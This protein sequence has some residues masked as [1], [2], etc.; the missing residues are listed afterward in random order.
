MRP[1][2]RHTATGVSVIITLKYR[3]WH[4][5]YPVV[6]RGREGGR[7]GGGREGEG[8]GEGGGGGRE[9]VREGGREGGREGRWEVSPRYRYLM[10]LKDIY[11]LALYVW[12]DN[13]CLYPSGRVCACRCVG[14][15]Q[16]CAWNEHANVGHIQK[17]YIQKNIQKKCLTSALYNDFIRRELFQQFLVCYGWTV[18]RCCVCGCVDGMRG[19]GMRGAGGFV[20]AQAKASNADRLRETIY[21][22]MHTYIHTHIYI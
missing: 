11:A 20:S 21:M 12:A 13:V 22:Y 4:P 19:A 3:F 6:I 8:E 18:A 10:S 15:K 2:A 9:A 7:E 14:G 16:L 5:W 17:Q 1:H